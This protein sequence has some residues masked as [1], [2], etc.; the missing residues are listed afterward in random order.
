[1]GVSS[2]KASLLLVSDQ[3]DELGALEVTLADQNLELVQT[4]PSGIAMSKPAEV[5]LCAV[6]SDLVP[7][8]RDCR[9]FHPDTP[10][11]AYGIHCPP[12]VVVA[13]IQAGADD[14]LPGPFDAEAFEEAVTRAIHL[15]SRNV[16]PRASQGEA[17]ELLRESA[18]PE[19]QKIAHLIQSLATA[20]VTVLIRGESGT[21]KEVVARAI[22]ELSGRAA[23]PFVK[24]NCAAL[25]SE[26]LE[27]ELFGFERG[28]FTGAQRRKLG[29]F[30]H[31]EGGTIFLDEIAEMAPPTPGKTPSGPSGW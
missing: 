7:A 13:A 23:N 12:S 25:P 22:H 10:L 28:A 14:F 19:I 2:K 31:A 9:H 8:L 17:I 30:E 1:M 15:G 29:K 11:I 27:S 21:G 5:I 18:N 6:Q 3:F 24:V 16:L 4:I 26:L 20:D